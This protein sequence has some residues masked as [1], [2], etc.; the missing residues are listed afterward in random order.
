MLAVIDADPRRS[1][2]G[3]RSRIAEPIGGT[4][5]LARTARRLLSAPGIDAL[6]LACPPGSER[7]VRAALGDVPAEILPIEASD[8]RDQDSHLR[9]RRWSLASWYGGP[10]GGLFAA[11]S[12]RPS[13]LAAAARAKGAEAIFVAPDAAPWIDPALAGEIVSRFGPGTRLVLST[14]P[15]G[16]AGDAYAIEVLEGLARAGHGLSE[17]VR[18]RPDSP[19]HDPVR[20]GI[21]HWFPEWVTRVRVRLTAD[22]EGGLARARALAE[23]LPPG[24]GAEDLIAALDGDPDLAA[25]PFPGE[26]IA[27]LS[28][29]ATRRGSLRPGPPPGRDMSRDRFARL[30]REIAGR[31]DARLTLG[32][33]GE[34]LLHPEIGALLDAVA[35]ARPFGL[36]I[37]TDAIE[38]GEE[39]LRRIAAL[40]PEF[41]SVGIDAVRRE[42]YAAL[43]GVDALETVERNVERLIETGASTV[44]PEFWECPENEAEREA[45]FDRWWP[46]TGAI[47]V[48]D[49]R[50]AGTGPA[51][52]RRRHAPPWRRA[53]IRIQEQLVVRG[54]GPF[55]ACVRADGAA[56]LRIAGDGIDC[57][58]TSEAMRALREAHARG[59]WPATCADCTEW[60]RL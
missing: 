57:A 37:H 16:L 48:R 11:E 46:R 20:V 3:L 59:A 43:H 18:F 15:P 30:L 35:D 38:V 31:D 8:P 6:V 14:A 51:P 12:Q 56:P 10:A 47:V 21:F 2:L 13:R 54:E 52:A 26:V 23:R 42:T 40:G 9:R 34:P 44:V 60:C 36:H 29:R 17:T 4:T 28:A 19:E 41:I 33:R 53:C 25:G 1:R 39:I 32:D 50:A 49:P 5:V 55:E 58:W 45:F 22:S 27:D 7:E 24:A